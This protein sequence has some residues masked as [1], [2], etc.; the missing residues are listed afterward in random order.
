M[1][2][3]PEDF[4]TD[5]SSF[6][7]CLEPVVKANIIAPSSCYA[8][9]MSLCHNAGGEQESIEHIDSHRVRFIFIIPLSEVVM[10]FYDN[11]KQCTSGLAR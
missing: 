10:D 3:N 2:T 8:T 6:K 4:P 1:V 9:L 11:L 7:K 5:S